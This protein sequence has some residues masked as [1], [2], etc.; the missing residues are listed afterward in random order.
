M[1]AESIMATSSTSQTS[2]NIFSPIVPTSLSHAHHFI[3]IKLTS[4]NYLLWKAQSL[5][6]FHGQNFPGY[7]DSSL[8]CPPSHIGKKGTDIKGK[9]ISKINPYHV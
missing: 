3:F 4:T 2:I 5:P 7:V 9:E 1:V 6:F 8:P